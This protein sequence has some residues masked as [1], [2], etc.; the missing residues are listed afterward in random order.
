MRTLHAPLVKVIKDP[1]V[2][3]RKEQK[4]K[5]TKKLYTSL[6]E[7]K[8]FRQV[9]EVLEEK[10]FL[11]IGFVVA[12]SMVIFAFEYKSYEQQ[13]LLDLGMEAESIETLAE[14]PQT[15]QPPPPPPASQLPQTITEVE[16]TVEVE[17]IDLNI[18]VEM[19]EE[20]VVEEV[21]YDFGEDIE[22]EKV[23]EVFEIVEQYPQPVGGYEAFYKYLGENIQ[24][25]AKAMRMEVSGRVFV[26]F[27]VE[28][29]G[30]LTD[31]K[32]VKGIGFGCDEEAVRVIQS[33]PSWQPGKQR[34]RPVRVRQSI[35]IFFV[36]K[37]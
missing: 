24:Y 25:P 30:S 34:G 11:S 33:A 8:K 22:E 31:I 2:D 37:S 7:T 17:E 1:P 26:Q 23:E 3:P 19:N 36:L 5:Y 4:S 13:E 10:L 15:T 18:D 16:N 29:D 12:L 9:R 28:K 21:V 6:L 27:I 14:I 32:V 20:T 35:P